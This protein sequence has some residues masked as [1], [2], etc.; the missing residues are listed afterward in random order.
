MALPA[1]PAARHRAVADRFADLVRGTADWDAPTPV[2][3]WVARDVVSHLI[4]W[5][6]GFLAGGTSHRLPTGPA[7]SADPLAAWQ[8][9]SEGVQALLDDP[10]AAES[11]FAHPYVPEQPL[12]TAID[13]FYTTD[14]FMHTWDL[15]RATGQADA[16]DPTACAEVLSGMEAMEKVIRSSGQFGVRREVAA[17]APAQDRLMAFIGRDPAWRP[18]RRTP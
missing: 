16:L 1:D 4:E 8:A 10:V 11:A 3:E 12:A 6:P 15:A 7:V 13:R 14:V 17:D 18:P 9:H 2:A 5:F